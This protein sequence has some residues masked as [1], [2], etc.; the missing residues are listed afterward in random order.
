MCI[1]VYSGSTA[2]DV[3]HGEMIK[4]SECGKNLKNKFSRSNKTYKNQFYVCRNVMLIVFWIGVSHIFNFINYL[5][6]FKELLFK[7]DIF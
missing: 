6:I 2:I 7:S 3:E 5:R 1:Y 4:L